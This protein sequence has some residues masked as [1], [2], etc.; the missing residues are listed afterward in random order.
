MSLK[1]QVARCFDALNGGDP[2]VF[3]EMYDPEIELFIP[4]WTGPDGG[5]YRGAD[6]V[7]RFYGNYFAQWADQRWELQE[8]SEHGPNVVFVMHWLLQNGPMTAPNALGTPAS[9]PIGDGAVLP[10]LVAAAHDGGVALFD[11]RVEE[12][13]LETVFIGLTGKELRD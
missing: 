8:T 2:N 11:V 7:N 5:L 4:A 10:R 9:A 1:D 3:L 6:E 13:S 12:P